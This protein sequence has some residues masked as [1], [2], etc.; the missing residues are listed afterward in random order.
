MKIDVEGSSVHFKIVVV[1]TGGAG[2]TSVVRSLFEEKPTTTFGWVTRDPHNRQRETAGVVTQSV[3]WIKQ[4][5]DKK[6]E[7]Y[8]LTFF[9][10]AGQKVNR[11]GHL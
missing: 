5:A 1:G 2:K 11:L 3:R 6:E 7:Q 9:D 4:G 10:F 8:S